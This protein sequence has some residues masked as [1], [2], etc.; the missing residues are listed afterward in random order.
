MSCPD[1]V[2]VTVPSG[3]S[4][5]RVA[6]PGPPGPTGASAYVHQQQA[7]AT[8]WTINHNLGVKPAVE[9]LNTGSQEIEGDVIHTSVN[10]TVVTFTS[11]VAGLARL[12]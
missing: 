2:R 12:T 11:A 9:L 3:P 4:V 6:I 7:A 1:V 5:V 8:T 10:Q